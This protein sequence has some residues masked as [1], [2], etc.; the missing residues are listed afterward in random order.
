MMMMTVVMDMSIFKYSQLILYSAAMSSRCHCVACFAHGHLPSI[1]PVVRV[2]CALEMMSD[3]TSGLATTNF[4][5]CVT[6]F[7]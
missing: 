6:N 1:K 3:N 4:L 7:P 5:A 2:A